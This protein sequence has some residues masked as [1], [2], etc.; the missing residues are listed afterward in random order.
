MRRLPQTA[1]RRM[2]WK[3][4]AGE[5][6]EIA[7]FPE[8]ASIDTFEWRV[9]TATVAQSGPFSLFPG[10][11]RTLC[12]LSGAGFDLAVEG[13]A[14]GDWFAGRSRSVFRLT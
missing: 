12:V 5:T 7:V 4:G 11:D 2:P 1:W 14:P 3:N 13:H 9:S 10:V 8:S 6:R